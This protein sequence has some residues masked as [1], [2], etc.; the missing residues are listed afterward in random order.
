MRIRKKFHI[1]KIIIIINMA[2][3]WRSHQHEKSSSSNS[4]SVCHTNNKKNLLIIVAST[5][6]QGDPPD[7]ATK[8]FR[9]L[10]RLKRENK[11]TEFKHL[12]YALL[13]LGDTNYDNFAN[14]SKQLNKFFKELGAIPYIEPGSFVTIIII[15]DDQRILL[16]F[17]HSSSEWMK[18]LSSGDNRQWANKSIC[19]AVWPLHYIP[20]EECHHH[21]HHL[22]II[23]SVNC[24]YVCFV[25]IENNSPNDNMRTGMHTKSNLSAKWSHIN[26][27]THTEPTLF[28]KTDQ[29]QQMMM[30]I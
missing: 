15:K 8:F 22:A 11:Q 5:T 6:G 10:R 24:V 19:M 23:E 7:K 13:G 26:T 29:Q 9:W 4:C 18:H 1:F 3:W 16:P 17:T 2:A 30:T 21:H 28:D 27:H 12:T 20:C 25:Y 14:F